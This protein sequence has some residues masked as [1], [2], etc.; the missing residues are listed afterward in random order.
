MMPRKRQSP[1]M[2]TS[3][4]AALVAQRMKVVATCYNA[5]RVKWY[6]DHYREKLTTIRRLPGESY[7][8]LLARL[9]NGPPRPQFP[10]ELT[11]RI[12]LTTLRRNCDDRAWHRAKGQGLVLGSQPVQNFSDKI[13]AFLD[14][15][16]REMETLL[17]DIDEVLRA[18]PEMLASPSK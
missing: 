8:E 13:A 4:S 11:L 14:D 6:M 9:R 2:H 16:L 15:E 18:Q 3:T 7:A 12:E 10:A 1:R 17:S 5:Q